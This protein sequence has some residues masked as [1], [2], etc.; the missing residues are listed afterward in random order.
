MIRTIR[1]KGYEVAPAAARLPNG[2]FAANL[3]IEKASGGPS[4]AVTF[5][6][7]DFFF[8][9]EHALAYASR[10]GRLWVDTHA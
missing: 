1:Y 4:R 8:E 5:N 3:T 9:E 2:L 10:W 7:I 6:A